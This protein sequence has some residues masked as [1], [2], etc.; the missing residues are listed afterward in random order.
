MSVLM[1]ETWEC[2]GAL[3]TIDAMAT[4]HARHARDGGCART[5]RILWML[6]ACEWEPTFSISPFFYLPIRVCPGTLQRWHH[7]VDVLAVHGVRL[8]E[9]TMAG[10]ETFRLRGSH[11]SLSAYRHRRGPHETLTLRR[12]ASQL[13]RERRQSLLKRAVLRTGFTKLA[14]EVFVLSESCQVKS[15]FGQVGLTFLN[16][17]RWL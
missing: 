7:L 13:L 4:R 10:D 12:R 16:R 8:L 6:L 3:R 11:R 17:C 14:G 1:L 9:R 5:H 2:S 15:S